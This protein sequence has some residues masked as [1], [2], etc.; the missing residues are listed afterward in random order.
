MRVVKWAQALRLRRDRPTEYLTLEGDPPHGQRL[1]IY[2]GVPLIACVQATQKGIYNSMLLDVVA[3]DAETVTL[4][5]REGG[6]EYP[7]SHEWVRLHTRSGHCYTKASAQGRTIPG[8][9][10]VYDTA[11]PRFSRRQLYTCS[12]SYTHL[13]LPTI[14]SV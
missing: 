3:Y 10:G 5:D 7:L 14:C 12:V 2:A 4:R 8:G 6:G 11:H 13:T 1:F 9:I